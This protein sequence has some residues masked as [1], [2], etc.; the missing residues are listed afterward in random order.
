MIE[1]IGE[2]KQVTKVKK[3]IDEATQKAIN[4]LNEISYKLDHPRVKSEKPGHINRIS[5][6]FWLMEDQ[7]R[8]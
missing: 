1:P 8:S 2:Q 4:G 5:K 6:I 7:L 3:R